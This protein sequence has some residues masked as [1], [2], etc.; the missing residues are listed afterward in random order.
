MKQICKYV[1]FESSDLMLT[2]IITNVTKNNFL[3]TSSK[4]YNIYIEVTNIIQWIM[5]NEYV[6]NVFDGV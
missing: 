5:L 6:A 4:K 3:I 2:V 1:L